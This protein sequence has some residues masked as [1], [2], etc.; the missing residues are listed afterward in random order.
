MVEITIRELTDDVYNIISRYC[1]AQA[2]II[3]YEGELKPADYQHLLEIAQ[4]N[5]FL[6][7]RYSLVQRLES[8][9]EEQYTRILDYLVEQ[10]ERAAFTL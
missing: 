10:S 1:H 6:H 4:T 5:T 9:N 7:M 2:G 8:C 3:A